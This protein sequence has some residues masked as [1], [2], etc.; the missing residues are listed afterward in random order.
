[1]FTV[2]VFAMSPGRERSGLRREQTCYDGNLRYL[3]IWCIARLPMNKQGKVNIFDIVIKPFLYPSTSD[4]GA[5]F[6][7][8]KAS[9]KCYRI[10]KTLRTYPTLRHIACKIRFY[11]HSFL[12][13]VISKHGRTAEH[14]CTYF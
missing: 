1:M 4:D 11:L 5:G 10:E 12:I 8:G 9:P 14:N 2:R 6:R 3:V 13:H 7:F